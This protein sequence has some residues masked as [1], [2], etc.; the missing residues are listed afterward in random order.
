MKWSV[1]AIGVD[2][3]NIMAVILYVV[4]EYNAPVF[5]AR[6]AGGSNVL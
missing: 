6:V 3:D 1:K 2:Y 4:V 5:N